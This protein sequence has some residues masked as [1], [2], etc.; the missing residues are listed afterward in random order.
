ML[1]CTA[2]MKMIERQSGCTEQLFAK[3]FVVQIIAQFVPRKQ[4][5]TVSGKCKTGRFTGS[6]ARTHRINDAALRP[7][8]AIFTGKAICQ[9]RD[10]HKVVVEQKAG[11]EAVTSL[12]FFTKPTV[13]AAVFGVL[14]YA[15]FLC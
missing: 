5:Q 9:Q 12:Q 10:Q 13:N 4:Q 3:L 8:A 14:A 7:G 15:Q 2:V 1:R 11:E 6:G